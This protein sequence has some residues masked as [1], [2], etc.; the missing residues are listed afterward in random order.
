MKVRSA[1]LLF[2]IFLLAGISSLPGQDFKEV[3]KS[4]PLDKDGE[5]TINTYKGEI[6]IETWDKAEVYV[7]AKMIPDDYGFWSTNPQKQ[8][9]RVDVEIDA[10]ANEVNIESNYRKNHSWFG[11]DT[12]AL[13]NYRIKMPKT[14]RLN[15][16][17]YKSESH[18][19]GLQSSVRFETY[20]GEVKISDLSGS[21]DLETYKG[22]IDVRFVKLSGDCRFET[23]KGEISVS[24]PKST[25][26]S[27]DADFGRRTDFYSNFDIE[28][29]SYRKSRKDYSIKEEVN[30]GG[31]QISLSSSKGRIELL[32]R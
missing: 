24:L 19:S 2:S 20:K 27:V 23:Y 1:I 5:V 21:I 14:A 9:D 3:E 25:A 4:F 32:E 31:A 26:F 15:I 22:E 30:G 13:V 6:K 10:S 17:D 8:L 16:K 11:N 7:Y 12:R 29:D 18:I 28:K